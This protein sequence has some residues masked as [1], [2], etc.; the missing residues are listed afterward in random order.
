MVREVHT[1]GMCCDASNCWDDGRS[2]KIKGGFND[3]GLCCGASSGVLHVVL[4]MVGMCGKIKGGFRAYFK[5][6]REML[7]G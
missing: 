6:V 3:P 7:L 2:G 4:Q 1:S 5:M